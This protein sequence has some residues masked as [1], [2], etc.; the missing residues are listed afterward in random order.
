ML[1]VSRVTWRWRSA[2]GRDA[3]GLWAPPH[4]ESGTRRGRSQGRFH[5]KGKRWGGATRRR[6]A[7]DLKGQRAERGCCWKCFIWVLLCPS[8]NVC[9]QL[10]HR[11]CVCACVR[12]CACVLTLR[13][14]CSLDHGLQGSDSLQDSRQL[15]LTLRSTPLHR[16]RNTHIR[17]ITN[18]LINTIICLIKRQ[19]HRQTRTHRDSLQ[20]KIFGSYQDYI[21]IS[22]F[23]RNFEKKM[24][25]SSRPNH[26]NDLTN[27][28]RC[29]TTTTALSQIPRV[30]Y[31]IFRCSGPVI[32]PGE[33]KTH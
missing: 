15:L 30:R 20:D 16:L 12:V 18:H 9:D 1:T 6:P 29:L 31:I 22:C 11:L 8:S 24:R 26:D 4:G 2:A 28:Q 17:L 10:P 13:L 19:L 25:L 7:E 5:P 23:F 27:T 3:S 32:P 14:V 21:F 33:S